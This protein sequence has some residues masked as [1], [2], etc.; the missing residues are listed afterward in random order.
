MG[1]TL[2]D[3]FTGHDVVERDRSAPFGG[4]MLVLGVVAGSFPAA[5]VRSTTATDELAA[6]LSPRVVEG[7]S[8]TRNAMLLPKMVPHVRKYVRPNLGVFFF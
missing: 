4:K 1:A 3:T 5:G 8:I 2:P 6:A 7:S